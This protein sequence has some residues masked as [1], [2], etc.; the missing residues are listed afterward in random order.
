MAPGAS[1]VA[2]YPGLMITIASSLDDMVAFRIRVISH[3]MASKCATVNSAGE[4][5]GTGEDV[6]V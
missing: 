2:W 3:A 1:L 6:R 4:H 5:D